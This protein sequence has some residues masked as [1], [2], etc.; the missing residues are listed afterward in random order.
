MANW[1]VAKVFS[2]HCVL[3]RDK[4]I[5]VFG[6]CEDGALVKAELSKDG[7]YLGQGEALGEGGR[8][9]VML[10][11]QQANEGLM[12]TVC[13]GEETVTFSDVAVGEVW[14]AGGQS[15]MELEIRTMKD[16]YELLR[17]DKNPNV[18]FYYTQKN[19]YIDEKFYEQ[20]N[21]SGWSTFG[22]K[23][24]EAWSAV[25]YLAAKELAQKLGVTVGVIG[26]NWGGTSASCWMS[27]ERLRVDDELRSYV[28]EY[29]AAIAGKS[30]AQQ[31]Q[32]YD[33][34]AQ[35]YDAWN[36]ECG[37]LYMERPDI[38]WD[39]VQA[40]L[41]PC[42]WPGPMNCKN[43]F[44]PAGLYECMLQR[45]A[46][47]TLRGFMY[48]QGESDDHK[49]QMYCKLMT[50]LIRQWRDDWKDL[51]LPFLMVQLPMHRYQGDQDYKHWCRIREA[52]MQV[53]QTVKHTG[54][55]VI[56][57]CGE[58]NEIHPKD[59]V[60]VGHRLALQALYHV[61]GQAEASEAFG[62]MYRDC[63]RKGEAME[64]HFDYAED[65]FD[66]HSSCMDPTLEEKFHAEKTSEGWNLPGDSSGFEVAGADRVFVPADAQVSGSVITVSA[67][68]VT[69][70]KYVRYLWT[71]YG[72]VPLYGRNGIPLAPFRSDVADE[73]SGGAVREQ[74]IQQ[75]MEL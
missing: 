53:Y 68:E 50:A 64:L 11:P 15:N 39:E 34:Y 29:E 43:P 55:A 74:K 4:N 41:G 71:N 19:S 32:E 46:P 7:V 6:W 73:L 1:K 75:V 65:G 5:C 20:E 22:E 70:P 72:D 10:P 49:P 45:V 12:L 14:L 8:F 44:R 51:E 61:Y 47:Y 2:D 66:A 13:C 40:L 17:T 28:E 18:R 33:T 54:I 27:R 3:Q 37:K 48:Y 63:I 25:G 56:T 57:D 69:A 24:A 36:A 30:E 67:P 23:S 16:G 35:E 31:V 9:Y 62:P 21:W 59:K 26:C 42:Q 58:F 60:P 38:T 52:Q